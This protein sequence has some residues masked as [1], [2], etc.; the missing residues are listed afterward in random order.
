MDILTRM[1]P[2]GYFKSLVSFEKS[3][4]RTETKINET[5]YNRKPFISS[6]NKDILQVTTASPIALVIKFYSSKKYT[7][8]H[9]CLTKIGNPEKQFSLT[10]EY[11]VKYRVLFLGFILPWSLDNS[12]ISDT[13]GGKEAILSRTASSLDAL[14][15]NS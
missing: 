10:L 7:I 5:N 13:S 2:Y 8:L 1:Y 4:K 14:D 3:L 12:C 15:S 6:S 9:H 11:N